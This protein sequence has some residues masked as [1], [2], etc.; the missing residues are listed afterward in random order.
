MAGVWLWVR[1]EWSRRWVGLLG[2]A[3]LIAV[4]AGTTLAVV[5]GARRTS[6][7][8]DRLRDATNAFEI[9]VEVQAPE[10]EDGIDVSVIPPPDDLAERIAA[11]DGVEG[12]TVATFL[13]AGIGDDL[14][15]LFSIVPSAERGKGPTSRLVAGR[16]PADNAPDEIAIN[17][18]GAEE[19]GLEIGSQVDLTTLAPDQFG[20]FVQYD[21]EEPAGPR[22]PVRV[23]GIARDIEDI[24]DAPEPFFL[25]SPGFL[26]RWGD[27]VAHVTGSALVNTDP[28]RV[29]EVVASVQDAV[30]PYFD[31]AP[32]VD[33]D[34]FAKRVRDTIDV[35]VTVLGVFAVAAGLTGLLVIG[36]ALARSAGSSTTDQQ[37]LRALGL[38]RRRQV[39]ATAATLAPAI[40]LGTLGAV[41]LAV[42]VSSL[43]PRGLARL[44]DPDPGLW[45]DVPAVVLGTTFVLLAVAAL[46][47]LTSWR[48][49]RAAAPAQIG[50]GRRFAVV[51]RLAASVPTVPGL[52]TRFALERDRRRGLAGGLAG[53]AGAAVLVG[54]LVGVATIERSRDHLLAEP[55]LFG[56]DWD[57]EMS[58]YGIE[59]PQTVVEQLAGDPDVDAVGTRSSL[60]A[61]DG[62]VAVRSDGGRSVAE[63]T[64]YV[65]YKGSRPPVVS[66]GRPPGT[67]EAA[68]GTELAGRLHSGIGDTIVV[69]GYDGDVAL[70]V[71][72]WLVNPGTD[73]LDA[74]LVVTPDT[75]EAM[76]AQDCPSGDD[77]ARCRI[78]V[79]GAGVA[80]RAGADH[81]EAMARLLKTQPDLVPVPTPSIVD[82]LGEIGSTPWLLA[83]FLVLIGAAGLAHSLS[84]S[85]RRHRHDVA[86]VRALGLRP[87]QARAVVRWQAVVPA[88]LG[89][90]LGLVVGVLIGRVIWQRIVHGVGA[91]VSVELS[92]PAV[93]IAPLLALGLALMLAV[94]AG[95]R[96]AQ[97]RPAVE[98]RAE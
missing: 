36:Q 67:G 92:R 89:A 14:G 9:T 20:A 47:L 72:G 66:E 17:E 82:N 48:A 41:P 1:T 21:F 54:G 4:V 94:L 76:R 77:S 81:D 40:I 93:L 24:S 13:A 33:R 78:D 37:T 34:N 6:S 43:F 5:N 59:D 73:E 90:G 31:V 39:L 25:P 42:G 79:E 58:F 23:T 83:G 56:A 12:V 19:W 10:T 57:L 51:D 70:R 53:V 62:E 18:A 26:D 7:A 16:L 3:V 50:G 85:V 61:D 86:V 65:W 71:T 97:L 88:L 2:L 80:F 91:L 74:G 46:L 69:E 63:P 68:I 27:E 75:L 38:D 52:G 11:V 95:R 96:V 98:L 45:V 29:D 60:L 84:V 22:I 28:R 64:A 55:R 87:V 44:A 15:T 30:G 8:F 49:V 35:E 32:A